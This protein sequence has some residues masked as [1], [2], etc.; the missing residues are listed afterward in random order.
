MSRK[1]YVKMHRSITE[2]GWY[3]DANTMR[4]FHHLIYTANFEKTIFKGVEI[5]EGQCVYSLDGLAKALG[6]TKQEI[7]TSLSHLKLTHEVTWVKK[8]FGLIISIEN[9]VKYQGKQHTLQHRNN[10]ASTP[11]KEYKNIRNSVDKHNSLSTESG[12]Q[13]K[14]V[15]KYVLRNDLWD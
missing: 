3:T 7:R 9:W 10:T 6:L 2:W 12:E 4:V 5:Q 13:K 8:P 15:S 14:E 11:S 1:G